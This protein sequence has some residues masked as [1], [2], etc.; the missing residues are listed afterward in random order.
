MRRP[1]INSRHGYRL[2]KGDGSGTLV[3]CPIH[4]RWYPQ[5]YKRRFGPTVHTVPGSCPTCRDDYDNLL[6]GSRFL[7]IPL[8]EAHLPGN[9][10]RVEEHIG[11][12]LLRYHPRG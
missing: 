1:W 2:S 12:K 3:C 10:E 8:E 11:H 4:Q 7:G 9:L 5:T 6:Y